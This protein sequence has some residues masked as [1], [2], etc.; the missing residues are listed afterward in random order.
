MSG[1]SI[2]FGSA[3]T[4][5]T[6]IAQYTVAIY[7]SVNNKTNIFYMDGGD[8]DKGKGVIGTVSG[9]SISFTSPSNF[10][11]DAGINALTAVYDS[12]AAQV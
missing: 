8:G 6:G 9:T 5:E 2:S 3:T 11:T 4:F 10:Y 7:D 12:N 1:T